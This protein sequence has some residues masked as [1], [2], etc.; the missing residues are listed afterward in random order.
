MRKWVNQKLA[1]KDGVHFSQEGYERAAEDLLGGLL[2]M[3]AGSAG[4]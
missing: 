1:R 4:R 2:H 3:R